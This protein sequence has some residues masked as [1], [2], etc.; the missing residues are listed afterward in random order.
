MY[1]TNSTSSRRPAK[2]GTKYAAM[3][4]EKL[5]RAGTDALDLFELVGGRLEHRVQRAE[6]FHQP[7][8]ERVGVALAHRE[9]QQHFEQFMVVEGVHAEFMKLVEHSA[10]V[11]AMQIV[12]HV[13]RLLSP[14]C[15]KM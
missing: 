8:C 3:R 11:P 5:R 10:A 14:S 4:S 7:V 13:R 6:V 15:R 12:R 1:A 9:K 2:R